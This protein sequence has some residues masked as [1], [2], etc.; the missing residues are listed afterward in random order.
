MK[1]FLSFLFVALGVALSICLTQSVTVVQAQSPAIATIKFNSCGCETKPLPDV[2]A[3]VNGA[4]IKSSELE[5]A[6]RLDVEQA[7]KAVIDARGRELDY[8]INSKLAEMEAKK[9]GV[10]V[11]QLMQQ[12]VVKKVPEPTDAECQAFYD[13]NKANLGGNFNE[14]KAGIA[15]YIRQQRQQ[16]EAEK[17]AYRLRGAADLKILVAEVTPPQNDSERS[18]VLATINGTPIT[19]GDIEDSLKPLIFNVQ[20]QVYGIR[21][22]VLGAK[23][24]DTLLLQE[25]KKRQIE[26]IALLNTEVVQKTKKITDEDAKK[27]YDENKAKLTGDFPALKDQIIGYLQQQE[28]DKTTAAF[29][30]Q[31]RK[32]A[33]I[34]IFL[35]PPVSPVFKIATDDRPSK[36]NPNAPVTLIE[37]SDYQCPTCAQTQPM[38]EAAIAKYGDS[39]RVVVRNYPLIKHPNAFRA[40]EA[41]EAARAQGKYWEYIAIL[42]QNQNALTDDKLKEYAS[43]LGLD[44]KAFDAALASGQYTEKVQRDIDDGNYLGITGTPTIFINGRRLTAVTAES[45]NGGIDAVLKDLGRK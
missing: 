17:F 33:A 19:S 22:N 3:T 35:P 41:S 26:P 21:L 37:F 13:D 31:L 34:Q 9:R 10:T 36:G 20:Q 44:R 5:E 6:V 38:I 18:R 43:R 30:E 23:V 29:A 11:G 40:A 12:E 28:S 39:L 1:S 15:N 27:F 42:Y 16:A 2:I 7:Q 45:I 25:A 4:P 8:Q 24:N 14:L 32:G